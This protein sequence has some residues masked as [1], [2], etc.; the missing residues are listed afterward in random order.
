MENVIKLLQQQLI[1]Q[2][3]L[4]LQQQQMTQVVSVLNGISTHLPP[5]IGAPNVPGWPAPAAGAIPATFSTPPS[6][7]GVVTASGAG[8]PTAL[9][10]QP[11]AGP[12]PPQGS[13]PG[14]TPLGAPA[15]PGAGP[16][17][18]PTSTAPPGGSGSAPLASAMVAPPSIG[19]FQPTPSRLPAGQSIS[20]FAPP[21]AIDT[22]KIENNWQTAVPGSLSSFSTFHPNPRVSQLGDA[23][24]PPGSYGNQTSGKVPAT[25]VLYEK[26][27]LW[28]KTFSQPATAP[29][30]GCGNQTLS[31]DMP[32]AISIYQ[33]SARWPKTLSQPA[34]APP[35]GCCNQTS[36]SNMLQ[37]TFACEVPMPRDHFGNRCPIQSLQEKPQ[38]LITCVDLAGCSLLEL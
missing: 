36:S 18:A 4:T 27:A 29:L 10:P 13:V 25:N 37:A 3:Q 16:M 19:T 30:G 32:E 24:A 2:Q 21:C 5:G 28:P 11:V 33:Q 23:A 12:V 14:I 34:T 7:F 26:P 17:L 9:P 38:P 1:L 15:T 22:S 6:G 8:T 20:R 31:S 35:G